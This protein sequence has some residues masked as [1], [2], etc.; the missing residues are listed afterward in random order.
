MLLELTAVVQVSGRNMEV[1]RSVRLSRKVD[2]WKTRKYDIF[3]ISV[4]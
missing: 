1:R 4:F 3:P 2:K